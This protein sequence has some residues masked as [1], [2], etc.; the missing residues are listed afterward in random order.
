MFTGLVY[1]YSTQIVFI[2]ANHGDTNGRQKWYVNGILQVPTVD[3]QES[4]L[5]NFGVSTATA[6]VVPFDA[7]DVITLEIY[8]NSGFGTLIESGTSTILPRFSYVETALPFT[9][10]VLSGEITDKTTEL[11]NPLSITKCKGMTINGHI[12]NNFQIGHNDLSNTFPSFTTGVFKLDGVN[13]TTGGIQNQNLQAGTF[14]F[15]SG[16]LTHNAGN[17][18]LQFFKTTTSH[19]FSYTHNNVNTLDDFGFSINGI[20]FSK[21]GSDAVLAG[22]KIV[23]AGIAGT[24]HTAPSGT[25]LFEIEITPANYYLRVNGIQVFAKTRS[26]EYSTTLGT[27]ASASAVLP[28]LTA[29]TYLNEGTVG[30]GYIQAQ[31]DGYI[32]SR[33]AITIPALASPTFSVSSLN[34][35][36]PTTQINLASLTLTNPLAGYTLKWYSSNALGDVNLLST[37]VVT[38]SGTYY[39]AFECNSNSGCYSSSNAFPVIIHACA[40]AVDDEA[41]TTANNAVII[42]MAANDTACNAPRVTTYSIATN[43]LNGSLSSLNASL[44]TVVYTPNSNFIG[45][46]TLT[47]NI[48]CDGDITDIGEIQI[49]VGTSGATCQKTVKLD[50][51]CGTRPFTF[52]VKETLTNVDYFDSFTESLNRY[53]IFYNVPNDLF[54]HNFIVEIKDANDVVIGTKTIIGR[55]CK[56]ISIIT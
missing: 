14:A 28:I 43:P 29:D 8:T 42:N 49:T 50:I 21:I 53:C 26:V 9:N 44:G 39:A 46:D 5:N 32:L 19:I 17:L 41:S 40:N 7:G 34:N 12:L 31:F 6:F 30:S 38:V 20:G 37:T 48:L 3:F 15:S 35:T 11:N 52:T 25:A 23:D 33:Q 16:A 13:I 2:H 22:Y 56:C 55:K 24:L 47:Y 51:C 18:S 1:Q 10:G 54:F 45:I 27:V 36:C 4:I